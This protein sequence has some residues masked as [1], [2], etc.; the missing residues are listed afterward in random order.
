M[1]QYYLIF[2][3]YLGF[4]YHG[5]QKQPGLKTIESMVDKTLAFILGQ[6]EYKILGTSRTDSKVSAHHSAFELFT[7][8]PLDMDSFFTKLNLNLPNDIRALEIKAVDN[9]FN[10]I[11]SPRVKEY[12]YLFSFG[13]KLYRSVVE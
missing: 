10:I 5:W 4:R 2:I 7:K 13:E 1:N 11:H 8:S 3:Q 6:G 9:T 12:V